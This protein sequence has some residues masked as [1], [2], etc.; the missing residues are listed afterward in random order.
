MKRIIFILPFLFVLT[1]CIIIIFL[2][3]LF[4]PFL[5][6]FYSKKELIGLETLLASGILIW[7]IIIVFTLYFLIEKLIIRYKT[8]KRI[9]DEEGNY[10]IQSKHTKSNIVVEFVKAKYNKYCPKIEWKNETNNN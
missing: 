9:Y 3:V 2:I 4:S 1:S 6:F 5:L 10:V 7:I 8:P